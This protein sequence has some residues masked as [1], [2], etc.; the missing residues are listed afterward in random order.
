[1]PEDGPGSGDNAIVAYIDGWA[2]TRRIQARLSNSSPD[3]HE[4]AWHTEHATPAE[5]VTVTPEPSEAR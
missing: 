1:M 5:P 4:A 2:D 3:D